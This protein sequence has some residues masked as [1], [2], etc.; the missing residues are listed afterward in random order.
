[1]ILEEY[2]RINENYQGLA[3]TYNNK[4]YRVKSI[5]KSKMVYLEEIFYE[6]D[7]YMVISGGIIISF[8]DFERALF[9]NK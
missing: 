2:D 3:I 7:E 8:E 4:R 5:G 1:M 9:F 6:K